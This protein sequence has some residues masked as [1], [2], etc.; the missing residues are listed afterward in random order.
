M[1]LQ[2]RSLINSTAFCIVA[3]FTLARV[4]AEPPHPVLPL[5]GTT[6]TAAAD[7]ILSNYSESAYI[8][9]FVPK[10][11]PRHGNY[12]FV[13]AV[14]S[15]DTGWS[16][17]ISDPT[18]LRS[19]PSGTMFPRTTGLNTQSVTVLSGKTI[20]APY[21]LAAG[22]STQKSF[23]H[24]YI[25]YFQLVQ[26]RKD[27]N[28]LYQAYIGTGNQAYA[29]RIAVA[30]DAW[31]NYLP[32]YPVTEKN[33][34]T[35]I[36]VTS[37][38]VLTRD[39][40][41]CSDHNGMSHEWE[42]NELN[43][44]DA[45]YDSTALA[46]L[47]T[48]RGYDVRQKI[49][50]D[51]FLNIG[52]Y[53]VDRIPYPVATATNLSGPFTTLARCAR[54]LNQPRY[55]QWMGGYLDVTV[56]QKLKRDHVLG[57]GVGYSIHYVD[58]NVAAC[59]NTHA[60]FNTRPASTPELAAVRDKSLIYQDYMESGLIAWEK[61]YLP[62]G[63][64]P[65]FGDTEFANGT[66]RN[67][68]SSSLLPAF[69]HLAL[70]AGTG[71]SSV[72][73]NQNF[74]DE[75][76]HQ[77]ADV[78]AFGLYAFGNELLGNIRY[79]N[80]LPGR[81]WTEQIL[82]HNAVTVDR[83]NMDRSNKWNVGAADHFY[84]SGNLLLW[85][86]GLNGL[87]LSEIDGR[88]AYTN[89]ASRYQRIMLLNTVDIARPYV[90]D[91]FRVAGGTTHDYTLHGAI[92]F[93]QTGES[94][95]TLTTMS[96]TY[97]LLENGE[98]WVEPT[99]SDSEF[100]YYGVFR[101]VSQGT[102]TG[103]FNVTFRDT[104]SANRDTRLWMTGDGSTSTVYLG[105]SPNPT[106][107]NKSVNFYAH[108]RPS[109]IVRK[110][111]STGTLNSLYAGVI[112]PLNNGVSNIQS[113]VRLPLSSATNDAVAL[114]VTFTS[115]RVD[116]YLI[117]LNNPRAYGNS[118]TP[119]IATADGVYSLT[120]RIGYYMQ[121]STGNRLWTVAASSFKH[122]LGTY[123]PATQ[124]YAGTITAVKR[125]LNGDATDGFI[126]SGSLPVGTELRGR[127]ISL[128]FGTYQVVGSSATQT[129]MNEMYEIDR[130]EV[131]GGETQV[132][133]TDDPQLSIAGTTTR[134]LVAPGRTFTGTTAYEITRSASIVPT[135]VPKAP[136][137]AISPG[138]GTYITSQAFSLSV[139]GTGLSMLYT[140]DGSDP[141]PD[142][143]PVRGTVYSSPV[144]V[145]STSTIKAV[146]YGPG[147]TKS[148]VASATYTI[149]QRA[150]APTFSPAPGTYTSAQTVTLATTS[151]NAQIRYTTD[152]SDPSST[153][154]TLY[155][156]AINVSSTTTLKAIAYGS[157]YAPSAVV[158]GAY[159][160]NTGGGG[161]ITVVP[162]DNF[163]NRPLGTTITGNARIEF[164]ASSSL[165]PGN[166]TIA[167]CSGSQTTFAGLACIV[168]FA[169]TGQIDARNG[170]AY[171]SSAAFTYSA[172][173]TYR[174]R[175]EVNVTNRTYSVYVNAPGANP[176]L[177]ANN[178]AF[179]T[180][181]ASVTSLNTLNLNVG[182]T[183]G[184]SL[185]IST[186]V[187]TVPPVPA[188]ITVPGTSVTASSNDG[189][190]PANA[191][192]GN[193]ATRW[194][195][196]GDGQ[197]LQLDLGTTKTLAQL[198]IAFF[199][200]NTRASIFDV[201]TS[202]NG[203]TW[204]TIATGLRSSGTSTALETFDVPDTATRYIR[205]IGRGNTAN[206]WNSLSEVEIWGY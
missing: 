103:N 167:L 150:A 109:L 3:L 138:S 58:E 168:R 18:R 77:R 133:L 141:D 73:L 99:T 53:F 8:N 43:A 79:S 181:Q 182:A 192:D 118:G 169:T 183:P 110:R 191:V 38:F 37:S 32:D 161:N 41:R 59:S 55:I 174:F 145:T 90:L 60:Y 200:G 123:T 57:E 4:V 196:N 27:L 29:R 115:G 94:S 46:Q 176:V 179:R 19:T 78:S 136:T 155:S 49:A 75:A 5:S 67:N 51:I 7:A 35:Y 81:Q 36:N 2:L 56:N 97:P 165:A 194:S 147:Y 68:G 175:L 119:T 39:L 198:K 61:L 12:G 163:V 157:T 130:V 13:P 127:F 50:N 10:H 134:E 72:Q 117:N 105:R 180:E 33:N 54:V 34:P 84:T 120:G 202:A 45:I 92:P 11:A 135:S 153:V 71:S 131:N 107:V 170:G 125:K 83:A 152:G 85:E 82:A 122:P 74:A 148:D 144:T 177:I 158:T 42:D 188:K 44:F 26:L 25:A 23:V 15:G 88:L 137:P 142:A 166:S 86:P 22:S 164:D 108:W 40:Q 93:D 24:S 48:E 64:W 28:T 70:G 171:A 65:S 172:G 101:N 201:Q 126:V 69:G 204:T 20:Q 121:N 197:W 187:V 21:Y 47:S 31:S 6:N 162:G 87:A 62:N 189:N 129:G 104:G 149:Q 95:L 116:N 89:E 9:N 205:Y 63:S 102:T 140:T 1:K 124:V 139:T 111:I 30:L 14:I 128:T 206:T 146:A 159:T 52:N 193:L 66:A 186:P 195:A 190:V 173:V 156:G 112:E 154:G 100:P 185:T 76:N 114:R 199:S 96:G 17:S 98:T 203:T 106:R 178:F 91:V 143:V 151:A 113:V 160:I 132:V 16:W 184:G 80:R